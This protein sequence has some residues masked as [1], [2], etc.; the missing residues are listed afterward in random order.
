MWKITRDQVVCVTKSYFREMDSLAA[1]MSPS[2]MPATQTAAAT[3]APNGNQARH[4]T[5]SSAIRPYSKCHTC[6][7]KWRSMSPS[8]TPATQSDGRCRQVPRKR[9]RRPR[10]QTGP[11]RATRV[12]HAC[13]TKWR[14]MSPSATLATQSEGRCRQAPR[15]PRK[16]PRRPRKR[17]PSAPPEA[18]QCQ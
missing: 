6:H 3:T 16:Q 14:S 13:H 5:Q 18:A 4:Q 10:R 15:L 8:A 12:S 11:K 9:P 7:A 2:A 17:E 1:W